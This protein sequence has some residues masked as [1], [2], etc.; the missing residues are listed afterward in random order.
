MAAWTEEANFSTSEEADAAP[1]PKASE[2]L[3]ISGV[4]WIT[5]LVLA[6]S[7]F[8]LF[9]AGGFR[10]GLSLPQLLTWG[11][12]ATPLI[13]DRGETWRLFVANFLHKD[14]LHLAFNAFALWNVGGALERAVRPADYVALLICC[15]LGTTVVS[16]VGSDSI[17]LGASGMAFGALGAAAAFGWRR[18]VRGPLRSYFG[19]R[20]VPWLLALFAAG[21]GS[22]GVDNWGHAGGLLV[23]AATGFFM[24]PR[25]WP[26][27]PAARRA[28][29]AFGA[30]LGTLAIGALAAPV[31]PAL[32]PFQDGPA[33]AEARMPLAWR[34]TGSGPDRITFTNGLTAGFRSSV[35][36]VAPD[37]T[38]RA[39]GCIRVVSKL[40]QDE[41]YR[42]ADVGAM[43][44]LSLREDQDGLAG[45][46]T[47]SDGQAA[48]RAVCVEHEA[49]RFAVVTLQPAKASPT[50]ARRIAQ[51][52]R[53][54]PKAVSLETSTH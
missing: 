50:L 14:A 44:D 25:A 54:A 32:G 5:V 13:L 11:A 40:V 47:G 23:G 38:G 17:S 45:T 43:R 19:L 34:R 10:T 24:T 16:A 37:C 33:G 12:K 15:A 28:A 9:L 27:E 39:C 3:A 1:R 36:V 48:V 26:G 35:A 20:I 22:A 46:L 49:S 29:G 6:A 51:S 21:L 2:W 4:P 7:T 41:L 52:L 42:L 30:L 18:G 53:W 8:I 31:L